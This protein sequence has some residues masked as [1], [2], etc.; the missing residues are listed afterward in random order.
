M[1][2]IKQRRIHCSKVLTGCQAASANS[3][4]RLIAMSNRRGFRLYNPNRAAERG[5]GLSTWPRIRGVVRRISRS[6]QPVDIGSR[7]RLVG[8]DTCSALPTR[9]LFAVR[10]KPFLR[11]DLAR[12][13]G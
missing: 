1:A 13:T 12:I 11:V 2:Y 10:A 6:R 7:K 5:E 3:R 8:H 9:G 4:K